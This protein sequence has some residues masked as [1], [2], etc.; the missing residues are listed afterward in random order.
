MVQSI[1]TFILFDQ[2]REIKRFVGVQPKEAL[3][4]KLN[5]ILSDRH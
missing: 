2:G 5:D 1:P 4:K 3:E